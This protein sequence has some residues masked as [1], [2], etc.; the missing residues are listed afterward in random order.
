MLRENLHLKRTPMRFAERRLERVTQIKDSVNK[1]LTI[2]FDDIID[3]VGSKLLGDLWETLYLSIQDALVLGLLMQVPDKVGYWITGR[4]FTGLDMC[5]QEDSWLSVNRYVCF[6]MVL[7]NFALWGVLAARIFVR[8]V[9][10]L[11]KLRQR[12]GSNVQQP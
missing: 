5:I 7:S 11:R 10:D 12:S 9:Q 8:C 2:V 3:V 4:K 6:V 1:F